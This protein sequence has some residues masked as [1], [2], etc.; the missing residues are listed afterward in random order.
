MTGVKDVNFALPSGKLRTLEQRLDQFGAVNVAEMPN[1][2]GNGVADDL[3]PLQA[4]VAKALAD[5]KGSIVYP[6]GATSAISDTLGLWFEADQDN[7]S[8]SMAL[9]SPGP[10][11]NHNGYGSVIKPT[12]DGVGVMVGPGQ[13]MLVENIAVIDTNA[14][15]R[16]LQD[17]S[18]VGFGIAGGDG[19]ASG[20]T[21]RNCHAFGMYYGIRTGLLEGSLGDSGFIQKFNADNC[22]VGINYAATQNYIQN[23]DACTITAAIAIEAFQGHDV[24]VRGGNY[25][26]VHGRGGVFT[27]SNVSALTRTG[28]GNGATYTFTATVTNPDANLEGGLYVDGAMN[29]PHFGIVPVQITNYNSGTDVVTLQVLRMWGLFH[30]Q[31]VNLKTATNFD[32]INQANTTLYLAERLTAL[33]GPSFNVTHSTHLENASGYTRLLDDNGAFDVGTYISRITALYCN[34]DPALP[35]DVDAGPM[36]AK[37]MVQ[38]SH[39]FIN[40]THSGLILDGCR[41]SQAGN[42]AIN[43]DIENGQLF[44]ARNC[45]SW[46]APNVRAYNGQQPFTG[47]AHEFYG[48]SGVGT[49]RWEPTPFVPLTRLGDAS[50]RQTGWNRSEFWGWFPAKDSPPRIAPSQVAT[51]GSLPTFTTNNNI[52]YPILCGGTVYS[53]GSE[54]ESNAGADFF[55]RSNHK[56]FSHGQNLTT[57]NVTNLAWSFY[58]KTTKL[59]LNA[60]AF[61]RVFP[62]LVLSLSHASIGSGTPFEVIVTGTHYEE[63]YITV[64]AFSGYVLPGTAGTQYTGTTIGQAAYSITTI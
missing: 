42:A 57:T 7:P 58:G 3:V 60:E 41:L 64:M 49:G 62:G 54:V 32:A 17:D 63:L 52:G 39:P 27:L 61:Q 22:A 34:W 5:G 20:W 36:L 13:E 31:D 9:V 56:G 59:V 46:K 47:A 15:Y 21:I 40:L 28:D 37:R 12:F 50:N 18:R 51:L 45:R 43:I 11:G 23:V 48:A 24:N 19:G 4:A 14:V 10:H 6:P 33:K 2:V 38:K 30:Y 35:F 53:I 29:L 44:E 8:F 26:G 1:F 55:L 16:E 25:S